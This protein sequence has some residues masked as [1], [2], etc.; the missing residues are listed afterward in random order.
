MI[1]IPSS[2][3]LTLSALLA[4]GVHP[5]S[6]EDSFFQSNGVRLRYVE[7]G[8]GEP[9]V[10]LHGNGDRI[11]S[12]WLDTGIMEVLAKEYRV[13]ALDAR[14][15]GKSDKPTEPSAYGAQMGEDVVRLLDHLGIR[16]AHV[17][18][19]SM[20]ARITGWLV[21][22]RPNRL[23]TATLGG[24]TYYVDT[25]QQ[26]QSFDTLA[27]HALADQARPMSERL[28]TAAVYRASSGLSISEDAM[29]ATKVPLL[30]II[31]SADT[32]RLPDSRRLKEKVLPSAEFVLVQGATHRGD[33]GLSL[34][35]EFVAA[36][37][38]FLATH[39]E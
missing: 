3:A 1:R 8:T 2:L 32:S 28:V 9:V 10:L 39:R 11:E 31:G 34:R 35:R 37:A 24:S 20:G 25:P 7:Q 12:E 22:N 14:G 33:Q 4:W 13:I 38:K 16:R 15:H 21:V 6:A 27:E 36:I 30:H 23:I 18:G 17:I 19:Y 29:A 26:R 5:A